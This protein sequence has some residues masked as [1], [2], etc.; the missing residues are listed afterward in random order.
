[1]MLVFHI[2]QNDKMCALHFAMVLIRAKEFNT[3]D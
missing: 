2:I 1:M 3:K